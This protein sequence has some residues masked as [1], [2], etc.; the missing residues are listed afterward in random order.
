MNVLL[1]PL[2]DRVIKTVP[3]P[4]HRPLEIDE[5]LSSFSKLP[6]WKL[7]KTHLANGGS[8]SRPAVLYLITQCKFIFERERTILEASDPITIVGDI[9]GQ[10]YDLLYILEHSQSP[11]IEKFL[12]LGDYVDRG[13]YSIEVILLL[14]S[15]KIN[16]PYSF[17]MLRGNHESRVMT[18]NFSFR[19]EVINK[20][21]LDIYDLIMETF[22]TLPLACVLNNEYFVVHGGI[23]PWIQ[24]LDD[25]ELVNRFCE[26]PKDGLT[27]DLLWADPWKDNKKVKNFEENSIR[28]CSYVFGGKAVKKF[29]FQN[30]FK[31]IIRAHEVQM[32]GYKFHEFN[33]ANIVITIFSAA[34]YCEK[35]NN[36]GSICQVSN[37]KF[38][39]ITYESNPQPYDLP[40]SQ[41]LLSW[42]IPFAIEKILNFFSVILKVRKNDSTQDFSY[43][44]EIIQKSSE[45]CF[46]S[47]T[48][49]LAVYNFLNSPERF[50]EESQAIE[51]KVK[52]VKSIFSEK[53]L[54]KINERLDQ[55]LTIIYQ[56]LVDKR[57]NV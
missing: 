25:I 57:P 51:K 52:K 22:D 43:S 53:D 46:E 56:D 55:F 50:L 18:S 29:L 31:A 17:L 8:V 42:S 3:L 48:D 23:S 32:Q 7:L 39:F 36:K 27:C 45:N 40:F 20:Y 30:K 54:M 2:N 26:T 13:N 15:I 33:G 10:F 41:D 24:T 21:G 35:F 4:P 37:S 34:N 14:F 38:N 47:G 16:Y 44:E 1:D 28:G 11:L 5:L 9:H 49:F 19:K 6:N 12:F